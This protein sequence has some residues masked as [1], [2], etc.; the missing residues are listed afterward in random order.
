MFINS[1][2]L[3]AEKL[4]KPKIDFDKIEKIAS[5]VLFN[6][7]TNQKIEKIVKENPILKKKIYMMNNK[8]N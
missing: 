2:N 1:N 5:Q 6:S 7:P 4:I 3:Q 8:R